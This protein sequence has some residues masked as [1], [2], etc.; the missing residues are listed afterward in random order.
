[1]FRDKSIV[2]KILTKIT[3]GILYSPRKMIIP[4]VIRYRV[5]ISLRPSFLEQHPGEIIHDRRINR[6]P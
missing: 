4:L 3:R 6:I 1:M 5:E 2:G